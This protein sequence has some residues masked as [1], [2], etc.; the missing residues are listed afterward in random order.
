MTDI[1]IKKNIFL[2]NILCSFLLLKKKISSYSL[3]NCRGIFFGCPSYKKSYSYKIFWFWDCSLAGQS[4]NSGNRVQNVMWLVLVGLTH[5]YV[6]SIYW[7]LKLL[8]INLKTFMLAS[9]FELWY[10]AKFLWQFCFQVTVK[11]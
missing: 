11:I 7:H 5:L 3:I 10:I 2:L 9:G 6:L 8:K 1:M 4:Q